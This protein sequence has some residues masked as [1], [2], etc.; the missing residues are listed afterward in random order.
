MSYILILIALISIV[1]LVVEMAESFVV[2]ILSVTVTFVVIGLLF[3]STPGYKVKYENDIQTATLKE[4]HANTY[5]TTSTDGNA[6]SVYLEEESGA[7]KKRS[8]S[9]NKVIFVPS[10]DEAKIEIKKK[11]PIKPSKIEQFWFFAF[12][13]NPKDKL[14]SVTIYVP[15]GSETVNY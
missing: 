4:I 14:E 11:K 6:V 3:T 7:Y 1:M 12:L 8:F 10:N 9:E 13:E 5:Y 2:D 15:E